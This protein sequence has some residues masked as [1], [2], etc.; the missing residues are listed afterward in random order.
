MVRSCGAEL[1]GGYLGGRST[2]RG[3][4]LLLNLPWQLVTVGI[5]RGNEPSGG[6]VPM[7]TVT[8]SPAAASLETVWSFTPQ[9]RPL[10]MVSHRGDDFL[11]SG[12]VSHPRH[13][14]PFQRWFFR[15]MTD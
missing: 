9:T 5:L 13:S 11:S 1:A 14:F 7:V 8:L 12:R 3:G 2:R 15:E 6:S 10:S 4:S